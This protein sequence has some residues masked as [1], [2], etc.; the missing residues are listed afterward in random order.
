M[1]LATMVLIKRAGIKNHGK[2]KLIVVADE[3]MGGRYG[4]GYV[5]GELGEGRAR[6]LI[7]EGGMGTDGVL[8]NLRALNMCYGEKGPLWLKVISHGPPGHG[9]VPVPESAPLRLVNALRE[10][11]GKSGKYRVLPEHRKALRVSGESLGGIKG[12]ILKLMAFSSF[13]TSLL[14]RLSSSSILKAMYSD[15]ASLTILKAGYKENVIPERAEAVLDVRLLPGSE[16]SA[17]IENLRAELNKYGSFEIK[18]LA[19][20]PASLSPLEGPFLDAVE[21]VMEALFPGAVLMPVLATG[22]TDSRYFRR[23]GTQAFGIMPPFYTQD[24]IESIHG[25]DEK[26]GEQQLVEGIKTIAA[27]ALELT[28]SET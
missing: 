18:V 28:V 13:L 12:F 15:T 19:E 23:Y 2:I 14:P 20:Y 6:Y 21:R 3:E 5:A 10:V 17:Y 4:A 1:E 9:S 8:G 27:L 25:L 26:I 11:L 16:P 24:Q 22:F 7:N